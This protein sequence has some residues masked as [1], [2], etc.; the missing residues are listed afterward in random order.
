MKAG[1]LQ[2]NPQFGKVRENVETAIKL[3]KSS[4]AKLLVLP[5]LFN[6]GYLFLNRKEVE[7]LAEEVPGGETC[8]KFES[9]AREKKIFIVG[10]LA[11]KDGGKLYNSS[12]LV[13]PDGYIGRYRKIH[14][15]N[16]EK[17]N[18]NPGDES[19]PVFDTKEAKIGI[20]ICFDWFF[21]ETARILALK[22]ADIICHPSNLVLPHAPSAMVTRSLENR[23]F[24][25]TANRIGKEERGG[26]TLSYIGQ[27]Q[28]LDTKG[29]LLIRGKPDEETLGE[30]EID[31]ASA[32]NKRLLE[33]NDLLK[34]RRTEL[35]GELLK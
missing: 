18:F 13:G 24:S 7:E 11:E 12:F 16:E 14:L 35:Y 17:L 26:K 20:M 3:I 2:F 25:I 6:T 33:H 4:T 34:D 8:K 10:G 29:T 28:I 1:F 22:G 30:A 21:P 9:L 19:P 15:F 23:V 31:P 32:R 27:S 5:E